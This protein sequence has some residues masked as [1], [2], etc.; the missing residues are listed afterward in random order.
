MNADD[1]PSAEALLLPGNPLPA[2]VVL[3]RPLPCFV[4]L[5]HGVNDLGE[6]Y[7]AQES[8]ICHGLNQRLHRNDLQPTH[9]HLPPARD[10]PSAAVQAELHTVLADPDAVYYRRSIDPASAW[11]PVV[12][13]YWGSRVDTSRKDTTRLSHGQLV[14]QHGNRLD[15]NGAK[16]GGPF[17]SATAWVEETRNFVNYL[18]T[19]ADW[20][21]KP[22]ALEKVRKNHLLSRFFAEDA[23]YE[24]LLDTEESQRPNLGSNGGE[25]SPGLHS[26]DRS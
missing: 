15:R 26:S 7:A 19:V 13:F 24:A 9:Y 8:G 23:E 6:A 4:I 5:V 10:D 11:N 14:D 22:K 17:T 2:K 21:M 16:E 20:R 12:P 25:A 1:A 18:C 3:A